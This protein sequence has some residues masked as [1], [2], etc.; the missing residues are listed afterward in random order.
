MASDGHG[1]I[2]GTAIGDL[3]LERR[4][5]RACAGMPYSCNTQL[6]RLQSIDTGGRSGCTLEAL[7]E[8]IE[9]M[10]EELREHAA[11]CNATREK[12]RAQTRDIRAAA[13]VVDLVLGESKL[14]GRLVALADLRRDELD[15]IP[16][17]RRS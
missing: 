2:K 3:V 15:G 1:A 5:I 17:G 8:W 7:V 16:E 4:I 12:L 14:V 9:E 11:E 10:G 13:R 6:M